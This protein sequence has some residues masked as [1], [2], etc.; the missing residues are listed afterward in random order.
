MLW[1]GTTEG[2]FCFNGEWKN[3]NSFNSDL[4]DNYITTTFANARS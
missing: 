3:Y 4:K 1:F 2:L